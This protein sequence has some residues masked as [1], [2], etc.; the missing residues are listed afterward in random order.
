MTWLLLLFFYVLKDFNEITNGL[1]TLKKSI[2]EAQRW[3][4]IISK[5]PPIFAL[6]IIQ[7]VK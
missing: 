6:E 7:N 2:S 3:K 4:L 5:F 1:E